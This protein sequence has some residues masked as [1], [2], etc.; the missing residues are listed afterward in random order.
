MKE[1]APNELEF[2]SQW[3]SGHQKITQKGARWTLKEP[4]GLR[5]RATATDLP[6]KS[7]HLKS[8]SAT[9]F[10]SEVVRPGWS[11]RTLAAKGES[12]GAR[13]RLA[14]GTS[15]TSSQGQVLQP[16]GN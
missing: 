1:N 15:G 4:G 7:A 9:I 8:V 5:Y 12:G 13:M 6:A 10:A 16:T 14:V 3:P 11:S 2:G